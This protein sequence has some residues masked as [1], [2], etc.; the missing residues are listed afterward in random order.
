M[1][2]V[3]DSFIEIDLYTKP[4]SKHQ[5]LLIKSCH[6]HHIKR[7]IPYSLALHFYRIC[8]NHESYILR[9]NEPIDYLTIRGYDKTFLK[10]QIQRAFNVP[11]TDALKD[12]PMTRTKT[13]PFVIT[14]NPA[15][16]NIA[17]LIRQHS[18]VLYSSDRCRNVFE[19]LPLVR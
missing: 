19:N 2:S 16:P 3:K 10:T 12:K 13:T 15:L 9:I 5:Y 8:S 1:V 18:H 14:Y 4:T 11:R 6:P 17:H 7:S